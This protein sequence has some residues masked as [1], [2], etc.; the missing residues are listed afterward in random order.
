MPTLTVAPQG[1]GTYAT[2]WIVTF[3]GAGVTGSS[4]ADGVYDITLT[5]A[6]V[7]NSSASQLAS[8]ETDTFYRL[9][10]DI[11]GNSA[12]TLSSTKHSVNATDF[13]GFALTFGTRTPNAGYVPGFDFD[14]NGRMQA[15]DFNAFALN[16]GK[17][18]SGF[19]LTI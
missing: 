9:Y 1:G 17:R 8:N 2:T 14:G 10:G 11:A 12:G 5:G 7:T 16:F 18:F 15:S 19:T 3:S 6:D 13:N 4:I